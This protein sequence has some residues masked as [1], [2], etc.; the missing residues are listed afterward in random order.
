MIW[1]LLCGPWMPRKATTTLFRQKLRAVSS[2][3]RY[4]YWHDPDHGSFGI[5]SEQT[6][7]LAHYSVELSELTPLQIGL[8]SSQLAT[9]WFGITISRYTVRFVEQLLLTSVGYNVTL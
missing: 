1:T 9:V 8:P 4:Y 2:S 3:E 5:E 6:I 7:L